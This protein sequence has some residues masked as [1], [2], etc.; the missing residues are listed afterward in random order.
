MA[1]SDRT[2][3]YD[4]DDL[5]ITPESTSILDIKLEAVVNER[6]RARRTRACVL[7]ALSHKGRGKLHNEP[8]AVVVKGRVI[9]VEVEEEEEEEDTVSAEKTE[10][11]GP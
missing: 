2:D 8:C 9:S 3:I 11:D 4:P 1:K 5:P 6:L 7:M 10:G